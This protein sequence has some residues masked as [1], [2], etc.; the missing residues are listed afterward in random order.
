MRRKD[1]EV[2]GAEELLEIIQECGVCRLGMADN[3]TPY[4][5]PLNFGYEYRDDTL[6]LYFHSAREGKKID[7]LKENNRVCF[8]M[9][10]GHKLTPGK[11]ACDYGFNYASVIGLGTVEF[12]EDETEKIRALNLLMKHQTGEDRDF[13]YREADLRAVAVYRLR[14]ETLTGKKRS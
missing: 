11:D 2:T 5:V 3:G 12:I 6:F 1:R 8:E 10:C 13:A 4:I 9:D 7:L 14:A